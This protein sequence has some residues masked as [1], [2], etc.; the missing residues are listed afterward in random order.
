MLRFPNKVKLVFP[1]NQA[2]QLLLMLLEDH[3]GP[4]VGF[5]S[6]DSKFFDDS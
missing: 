6:E 3:R 4:Q 1:I 2:N 5:S